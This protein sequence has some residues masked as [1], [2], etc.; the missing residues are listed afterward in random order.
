MKIN[1]TKLDIEQTGTALNVDGQ[2]TTT[3]TL[4]I[5]EKWFI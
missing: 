4:R 2:D 1:E 3:H 5:Y